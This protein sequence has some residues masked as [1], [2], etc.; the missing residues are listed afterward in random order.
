M[1][2]VIFFVFRQNLA[3]TEVFSIGPMGDCFR[4]DLIAQSR[5]VNKP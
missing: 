5:S 2:R 4:T 1:I 3:D